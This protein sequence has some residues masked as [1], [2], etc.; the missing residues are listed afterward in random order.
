[1]ICETCGTTLKPDTRFCGKC[2]AEVPGSGSTPS[3]AVTAII[4]RKPFLSP[5]NIALLGAAAA[6]IAVLITVV[7]LV[8]NLSRPGTSGPEGDD[9]LVEDSGIDDG[10]SGVTD[11][12][13]APVAIQLPDAVPVDSD[14]YEMPGRGDGVWFVSPSGNLTCGITTDIWGCA[15]AEKEWSGGDG[16]VWRAGDGS[17]PAVTTSARS[18]FPGAVEILPYGTSV[19]FGSVTCVSLEPHVVC[20]DISTGHGFTISRNENDVF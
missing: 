20:A 3:P 18:E 10:G 14:A 1:M 8:S 9:S 6:V 13:D 12:V 5:R 11:P 15:I 4:P 17:Q 19:T 7:V 2:G 16:I